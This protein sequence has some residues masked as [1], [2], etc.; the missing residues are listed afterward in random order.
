[1][2]DEEDELATALNRVVDVGIEDAGAGLLAALLLLQRTNYAL[3]SL[4]ASVTITP[5]RNSGDEHIGWSSRPRAVRRAFATLRG[6]DSAIR[7]T[8]HAIAKVEAAIRRGHR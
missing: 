1:M 3:R 8:A 4:C 5:D 2:I 6:T 7:K